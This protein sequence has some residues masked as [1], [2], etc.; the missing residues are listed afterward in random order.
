MKNVDKSIESKDKKHPFKRYTMA[1]LLYGAGDILQDEKFHRH[2]EL[3]IENV[4]KW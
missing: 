4:C 2:A 1:H 3:Q